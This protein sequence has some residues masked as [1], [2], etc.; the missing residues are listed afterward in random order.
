MELKRPE[1]QVHS[2]PSNAEVQNVWSYTST[3]SV[4]LHGCTGTTTPLFLLTS[5]YMTS[6]PTPNKQVIF[7]LLPAH[8]AYED[9][10][11][12][13]RRNVGI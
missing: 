12:S 8:T 4:C 1:R 5:T 7:L 6:Y 11:D 10:T 9:G 2:P 3:P 13:V